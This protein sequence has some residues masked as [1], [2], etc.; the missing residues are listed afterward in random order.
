MTR[1]DHA[2]GSD[3]VFEAVQPRRP[4]RRRRHRRQ[5]AGRPADAR[6]ARWS[7]PAS[8]R[9]SRQG[10]GH[11]HARR[12]D[13]ATTRSGPTPTS[14][15]WWARRWRRRQ[16][17]A[18]ALFHARHRAVGRGPALSPHRHLRLPARGAWSGSC[19]CR[20]RRWNCARSSSS[21]ARSRP[22][23][24]STSRSLTRFRSASIL[25]PT[26]SAPAAAHRSHPARAYSC[27]SRR[28]MA[29]RAASIQPCRKR[30]APQACRRSHLLSGRAGRQLASRRARRPIPISS[31]RPARRSRTRWRR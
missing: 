19:R 20:R 13:H 7:A 16:S 12:R 23:C 11:R 27:R 28:H 17:S 26:S 3:R 21:C 6:S 9:C 25:P 24:A 22:A 5:P 31:R 1:A 15:R 10:T 29:D 30:P 2:S 8:R 4:G 18:R 14:S